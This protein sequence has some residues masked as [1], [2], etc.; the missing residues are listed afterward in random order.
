MNAGVLFDMPTAS[1][2]Y[3]WAYLHFL[4]RCDMASVARALITEQSVQIGPHGLDSDI[5][6]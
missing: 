1:L 4:A 3:V 5:G 6:S 2:H